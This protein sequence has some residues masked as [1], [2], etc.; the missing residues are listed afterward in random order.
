[1]ISIDPETKSFGW[2]MW[3]GLGELQAC[4]FHFIPEICAKGFPSWFEWA[5]FD[6]VCEEQVGTKADSLPRDVVMRLARMGGAVGARSRSPVKWVSPG[7]WKGT[8]K[9]EVTHNEVLKRLTPDE[10]FIYQD[11][12]NCF[13][14]YGK[15]GTRIEG[16]ALPQEER[17]D[18]SCAIGIGLFHLRRFVGR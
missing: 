13:V 14:G 15:D 12:V 6:V 10:L 7:H 16:G 2:A 5:A 11:T 17:M 8:A 9:R 4:G 1:M 18:V 3:D